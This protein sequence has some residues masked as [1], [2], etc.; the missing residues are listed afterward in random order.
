LADENIATGFFL[1]FGYPGE[2]WKEI[3]QTMAMIRRTLPDDMGVSVSYPLP[4]TKFY[5]NV[6]HELLE[7]TNWTDSGD[8]AMLFD[9]PFPTYFYRWLHQTV[10]AELNLHRCWRMMRRSRGLDLPERSEKLL[11]RAGQWLWFRTGLAC[12]ALVAGNQSSN[13]RVPSNASTS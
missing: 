2:G 1:Q 12:L 13:N 4:G 9:G 11:Y 10:H 7:Q 3:K 5:E 6:K 8:L